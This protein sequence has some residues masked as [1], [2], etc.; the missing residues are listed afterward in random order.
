MKKRAIV[1][2]TIVLAFLLFI[3]CASNAVEQ[4]ENG[5]KF[6]WILGATTPGHT[7][8]Q[9]IVGYAK[10][11]N[12]I[13]GMSARCEQTGASVETT[14]LIVNGEIHAGGT[15]DIAP[16]QCYRGIEKFEGKQSKDI[17]S[18][19]PIYNSGAQLVVLKDSPIQSWMDLEGK[20]VGVGAVGSTGEMTNKQI[21]DALGLGYEKTEAF[22]V[23]H[24]EMV[25]GL[26]N[27][28]LDAIIET[29]G[30]PTSGILELQATHEIRIVPLTD[31][32][33]QKV[34]SK[35]DTLS[36][37]YIPGG[38]YK[39]IDDDSPTVI[40]Y[41]IMTIHKDIPE[42]VVYEATKKIWENRDY[43][44]T[45]HASQKLLKPETMCK[46]I[47]RLVPLHQGAARY[48]KEQGW[49]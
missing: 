27:G 31:E 17:R 21:L 8:Y 48:Y 10:I 39:G 5:L 40:A 25:D 26:K 22:K 20:R 16:Y 12:E 37:G 11:I 49:I 42:E 44:E 23:P 28:T 30:I 29:T 15:G 36:A 1:V 43:L 45:V 18:W 33:I 7:C 41:T 9:I 46:D 13:P 3:G 35:N 34:V 4:Q 24:A 19:L 38:V 2:M 14:T 47:D 6:D 32:E